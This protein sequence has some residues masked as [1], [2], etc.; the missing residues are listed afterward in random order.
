MTKSPLLESPYDYLRTSLPLSSIPHPS[1]IKTA[2]ESQMNLLSLNPR[3]FFKY[4]PEKPDTTNPI[5]EGFSGLLWVHLLAG[6]GLRASTG[7]LD[8]I[9]DVYCV[10]ECDRSHKART[11]VRSGEH[12]F[13]WDE[14]FELDMFDTKEISF[15]LYTWDPQYRHKLCYKGVINLVSLSLKE[16]PVHS[17][18]L[19]MEPRGTLYVKLR[20]KD[21]QLTFQRAP[22]SP[23]SSTSANQ[24]PNPLFGV[25]VETAVNREN[26]GLSVPLIIK[27]CVEEIHK[28]GLDLVGIYRLC[29][30]AVRKNMLRESFEKNAWLVDLSAEHVPDINVITSK[31]C[32]CSLTLFIFLFCVLL[33]SF[34][35]TL[36]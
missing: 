23:A 21:V 24:V 18:A 27:R 16:T 25:D 13:D 11:V 9:R 7:H 35:F 26:A 10:I 32:T 34:H 31:S 8:N 33:D 29:G 5:Q 1:P 36:V 30:S 14:I 6:R 28:R 20:Y 2:D 15:L 3:D 22:Y 19:K 4:R 17:L 12:S